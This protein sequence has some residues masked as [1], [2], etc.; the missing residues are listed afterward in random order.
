MRVYTAADSVG[1]L[2]QFGLVCPH[3]V[4]LDTEEWETLDRM[5]AI[6]SVPIIALTADH[7]RAESL[8]H[9]ADFFVVKPP[10]LDELEAKVR[11][12]LRRA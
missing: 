4:I 5:R 3:L 9:G 10:S 8:H 7:A 1:G 11:A 12:S 2:F 6:S